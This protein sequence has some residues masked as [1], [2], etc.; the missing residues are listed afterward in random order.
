MINWYGEVLRREDMLMQDLIGLLKI[1]S[2]KDETT[3]SINNPMGIKVG[4]A[5]EYVLNLSENAGFH[6][7][8]VDGYA[9]YAQYGNNEEEQHIGLLC[10]VDVVPATGKW[11]TPPFEPTVRDGKLFARGAIDDKG[12]TLAAFYGLKIVKE[13]NLPLKN[14]VRIIF[15]T[16]EESGM[17]CMKHY[18]EVEAMPTIGFAP[19]ADFPI[20]HAEKGQLNVKVVLKEKEVN[21]ST[22]VLLSFQSGSRPNMVPERAIAIVEGVANNIQLHYEKFCTTNGVE[23][24]IEKDGEQ[25]HITLIGKSA[26]GMEPH[27]GKNAATL[28]ASFLE[29]LPFD[30]QASTFLSFLSCLHEGYDGKSLA[31]SYHDEITG[32]LTVNPGVISYEKSGEKAVRLNIRCPVS[33]DFEVTKN[34]LR[35]AV[36]TKGFMI[37]ELRE[38]LPHHVSADHPMIQTL[39]TV[40]EEEMNEKATLLSTGGATYARF[41][42]KGVAFGMCFPGKEMTAHQADEYIEIEDLLKAT[43]I[44]ARAIY[45]LGNLDLKK[46]V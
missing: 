26:H 11:T 46:G 14:N 31:I 32:P 2:V 41:M 15:G 8:N 39:Q 35:E 3:K 7:K 45:E 1:D 13:L 16:D 12:P 36:N 44:Y 27:K 29:T 23:G 5:L 6:T 4:K 21:P 18:R 28:L 9:G 24:T 34:R 25:I 43:A 22:V 33:L 19:D 40:Y 42:E 10:H 30:E 38:S 20:I 37:E 17:S